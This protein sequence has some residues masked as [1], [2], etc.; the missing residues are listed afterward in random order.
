MCMTFSL[1][2]LP[3][4]FWDRPKYGETSAGTCKGSGAVRWTGRGSLGQT[5][6]DPETLTN[7]FTPTGNLEL[8]S[9]FSRMSLDSV[10]FLG[11]LLFRPKDIGGTSKFHTSL[12]MFSQ[13]QSNLN[14]GAPCWVYLIFTF[15]HTVALWSSVKDCDY[16]MW[17]LIRITS[18]LLAHILYVSDHFHT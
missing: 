18:P 1:P 14:P 13:C 4:Q 15:T 7:S 8:P 2:L 5:G 9:Q 11:V 12:H 10:G 16:I 6:I 17:A 3:Q